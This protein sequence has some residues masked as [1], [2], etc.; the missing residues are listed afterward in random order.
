SSL[1]SGQLPSW[2]PTAST[3]GNVTQAG[4]IAV[5]DATQATGN[6]VVSMYITN[7]ASLSDDYSSF[8]FPIDVFKSTGSSDPTAA[9]SWAQDSSIV[10][11]GSSFSSFLT[12]T[13]GVITFSLPPGYYYDL[14]MDSATQTTT[15]G[16]GSYFCI[17]TTASGG[18]LSPAFF[19]TATPT[20]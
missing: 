15:G 1:A 16:G 2:S 8:A 20:A 17:S 13:T 3:A 19:V 7:L 6:V 11:T 4:D 9:S 14:T 5:I 12:D 18:S 10:P